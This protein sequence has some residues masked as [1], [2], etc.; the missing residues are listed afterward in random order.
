[1][2][3][4]EGLTKQVEELKRKLRE[5]E[6]EREEMRRGSKEARLGGESRGREEARGG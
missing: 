5:A 3:G 1:M 6:E 2:A 4:E